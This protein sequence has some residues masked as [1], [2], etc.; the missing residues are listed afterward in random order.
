[1]L[2]LHCSHTA[3]IPKLI[4]T[5]YKKEGENG[6]APASVLTYHGAGDH[7]SL[8]T[9]EQLNALREIGLPFCPIDSIVEGINES[10]VFTTVSETYAKEIQTP[11]FGDGLQRFMK[12]KAF[13]GKLIGILN[14][15]NDDW[16]PTTNQQLKTWI[17]HR[18]NAQDLSCGPDDPD[19]VKKLRMIRSELAACLTKHQL[20]NIDPLKPTF[21]YLGRYCTVQKGIDKL[22]LIF[23]T[24]LENGAQLIC[25]GV[26]PSC[27][28]D[29]ILKRNGRQSPSIKPQWLSYHSG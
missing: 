5:R 8:H 10:D 15:G 2:H 23:E 29:V 16:N 17:S 27:E 21:L 3:L 28:A 13:Q 6:Q 18:G 9:H 22:P 19:L 7:V 24:L 11:L 25:I 1:M 12:I 20:G 4:R 26:E 14:G